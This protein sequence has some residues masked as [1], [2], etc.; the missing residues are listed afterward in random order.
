MP[1]EWRPAK[2][3][4]NSL[5]SFQPKNFSALLPEPGTLGTILLKKM[6]RGIQPESN[7]SGMPCLSQTD[8]YALW[9]K[10]S[11]VTAANSH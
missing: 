7:N 6:K 8:C 11:G 9:K 1:D 5:Q 10:V 4:Q 2:S 3:I